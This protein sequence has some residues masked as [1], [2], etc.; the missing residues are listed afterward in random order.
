[1]LT[2]EPASVD[3]RRLKRLFRSLGEADRRTLLAFAEFLAAGGAPAAPPGEPVP[4]PRP[5]Q[6]TVIAAIRRLSRTYPMLD[7]G[8]LL[9]A[10][11]ARMSAHVLQGR[12]AAA[13]IDE[14]EALFLRHYD[15]Y[16][17]QPP[18]VTGDPHDGPGDGDSGISHALGQ[19]GPDVR[20]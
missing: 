7:R 9:N 15:D 8:P 20:K 5:G 6:E 14:L 4:L 1:M 11:A 19:E 17:A 10:T 3:E 2:P 18:A 16:R 13:V 12:D